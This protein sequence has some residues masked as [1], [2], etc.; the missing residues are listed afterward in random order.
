MVAP[1]SARAPALVLDEPLSLWGGLDPETG[2]ICEPRHPQHGA[3][4]TGRILVM[5]AARGSSSSASVLAE[6]VRAGTAPAGIVLGEPDLILAIGAAV[7]EELYGVR[8]PIAVASSATLAAIT[9]GQA[10]DIGSGGV[11]AD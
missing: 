3:V 10:V 9:D 5:P 7:A 6:A 1:G 4:V 11:S 8:V 2:A